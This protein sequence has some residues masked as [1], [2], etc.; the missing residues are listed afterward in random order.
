[1]INFIHLLKKL[2][3]SLKKIILLIKIPVIRAM[4]EQNFTK[5]LISTS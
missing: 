3:I 1:V 2:K 5:W 4:K